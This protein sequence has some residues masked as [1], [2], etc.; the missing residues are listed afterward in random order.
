MKWTT[1]IYFDVIHWHCTGKKGVYD[2][3][4]Y[5]QC[6]SMKKTHLYGN[7]NA[8]ITFLSRL[9]G[10]S[11]LKSI[12]FFNFEFNVLWLAEFQEHSQAN[13]NHIPSQSGECFN[14]LFKKCYLSCCCFFDNECMHKVICHTNIV[15]EVKK[16]REETVGPVDGFR[17]IKKKIK[18]VME[19]VSF[20]WSSPNLKEPLNALH[21][22]VWVSSSGASLVKLIHV[23]YLSFH[24]YINKNNNT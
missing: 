24:L 22:Q 2:L 17:Y 15:V 4:V 14:A 1:H 8:K 23:H 5:H 16:H 11:V 12:S 10:T 20:H 6:F 9:F 3:M 7:Y 13:S 19:H 21:L 18:Y